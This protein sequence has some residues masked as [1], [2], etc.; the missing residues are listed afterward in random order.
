MHKLRFIRTYLDCICNLELFYHQEIS[1]LPIT[2]KLYDEHNLMKNR[3]RKNTIYFAIPM[4]FQKSH[5]LL[6]ITQKFDIFIQFV[7]N[8]V[9]IQMEKSIQYL[10]NSMRV[11]NGHAK[12]FPI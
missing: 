2:K 11:L 10:S 1:N 8:I 12:S 7:F 5:A 4:Q 3:I 6:I 9:S